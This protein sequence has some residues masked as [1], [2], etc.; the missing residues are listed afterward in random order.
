MSW[1]VYVV[2]SLASFALALFAPWTW[3]AGLAAL[4]ALLLLFAAAFSLLAE[5]LGATSRPESVALYPLAH[6]QTQQPR[7]DDSVADNA[8]KHDAD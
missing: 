3:L 8:D 1:L 5:R 6:A 7:A 4:A 2:L